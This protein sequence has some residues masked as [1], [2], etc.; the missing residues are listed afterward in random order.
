MFGCVRVSARRKSDPDMVR[1]ESWGSMPWWKLVLRL[2]AKDYRVAC[3]VSLVKLKFETTST[4]LAMG[5]MP[6]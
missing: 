3:S 1:P 6:G 5:Q 2:E 4:E